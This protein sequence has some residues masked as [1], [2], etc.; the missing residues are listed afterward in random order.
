M[1]IVARSGKA[2]ITQIQKVNGH[3]MIC[4]RIPILDQGKVVAVTGKV[5]FQDVDD[6]FPRIDRFRK[7][8][9]EPESYKS[10]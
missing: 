4:Q 7:L 8:K 9:K 5:M 10:N 3:E 2:E 6:L 1:H